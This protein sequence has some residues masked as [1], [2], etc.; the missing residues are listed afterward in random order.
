MVARRVAFLLT[1]AG[2]GQVIGIRDLGVEPVPAPPV[3]GGPRTPVGTPGVDGGPTTPEAGS[4]PATC[5]A[6]DVTGHWTGTFTPSGGYAIGAG[7]S[8]GD[9]EQNCTAITGTMSIEGCINFGKVEGTIDANGALDA[10]VTAGSTVMT[11]KGTLSD[12]N[13]IQGDFTVPQFA[14]SCYYLRSGT[15]QIDRQ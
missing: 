3:D 2:C 8:Q 13:R 15:F 7:G 5:S 14:Y 4:G 11:L 9:L 1:L 10:T 6:P 12:T